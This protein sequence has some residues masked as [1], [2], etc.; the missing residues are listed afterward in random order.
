MH[1]YPSVVFFAV[2]FFLFTTISS[3]FAVPVGPPVDFFAARA[4]SGAHSAYYETASGDFNGDGKVDALISTFGSVVAAFGNGNGTFSEPVT[5]YAP[6]GSSYISAVSGDFNGD[7]RSDAAIVRGHQTISNDIA[8]YLGN[9][10]RTFSAPVFA[11]ATSNPLYLKTL[12]YDRDGKIDLVASVSGVP[13][14]ALMFYRSQG[15]GSFSV[16]PTLSGAQQALPIIHDFNNDTF[17]DIWFYDNSI[18]VIALNTRN[19][20]F[21]PYIATDVSPDVDVQGFGDFNGDGKV[22][23]VTMDGGSFNPWVTIRLASGTY[24]YVTGQDH[25][26]QSR[27]SIY[28]SAVTDVDQDNRPDLIFNSKN[29]T[30]I[31]KGIGDGTFSSTLELLD[32]GSGLF[33]ED[34][35]SDGW[36]D[37]VTAQSFEFVTLGSIVVLLNQQNGNFKSAPGFGM[38]PGTKDI[39][40]ANLN[41]DNFMDFVAVTSG[42]GGGAGSLTV[43][44]QSPAPGR[45]IVPAEPEQLLVGG[46]VVGFN[47]VATGDFNADGRTDIAAAGHGAYGAAPNIQIFTNTGANTFNPLS[48]QIGISDIY[49]VAASDLNSDGRLDLITTGYEGI[50]TSFGIGNGTFAAP[51]R[52]LQ[53]IASNRIAVGDFNNDGRPDFAV[54]TYNINKIAIL[55]NNGTGSFTN[56]LNIPVANGSP[57]GIATAD[58]NT[59]GI[60]D[61]IAS[62]GSGVLV[63]LG[64]GGGNFASPA[65]YPVSQ[66]S[67]YGLA[68]A[69]YNLDSKPDAAVY[70]ATNT[71]SVLLN[72][73]TGGLSRETLWGSGVET[74]ALTAG[75]LNNDSKPDLIAGLTAGTTGYLKLFFNTSAPYVAPPVA[76]A[77]AD[78]DGDGKSD[79]SVYRPSEGNWYLLRSQAGF[80]VTSWGLASD[81]VAPGDFDGD[82]KA[83]FAVFRPSEGNWYIANSNGTFTSGQFGLPGD[84]PV[85]A[86]YDGDGK[87]DRAVFRPSNSTWYILN[88]NGFNVREQAFGLTGDRPVPGDYDGDLKADLSVFR[89]SNGTWYRAN[90]GNGN[91]VEQQWGLNGDIPVNA[92]YDGD[93]KQDY[94]VFRPSAA[95]WYI[96]N[97]S[98]GSYNFRSFGLT[99]DAPVPGDYNGDGSDDI[100]VFRNGFWYIIRSNEVYTVTQFGLSGDTAIPAK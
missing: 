27:D 50:W 60:L 54:A 75:D 99:G 77:R 87:D 28:L 9:G 5:V 10:D 34:V 71:I 38:Q 46:T 85:P 30:L 66:G 44:F 61:L 23:V 21:G 15:D 41:A 65:S 39:A 89:P 58:M 95:S 98:N 82:G 26:F 45:S 84:I 55:I 1:H 8:I 78:F 81:I 29:R 74:K 25:Q 24:T 35:N 31:R 97:S 100:A 6:G 3:G 64:T 51:V 13:G 20:Q 92:D 96:L 79:L 11:N 40:I 90:S 37:I 67:G 57:S 14:T 94:A 18:H 70:S 59:D 36:K 52:Y 93:N 33:V 69:D 91:F 73:G 56:S 16:G 49:D 88:S 19:G 2:I 17:P 22:D 42:S 48:F 83:D 63:M 4:F 32:G 53:N 7:G 76:K 80:N 62:K 43:F 72:N 47:S 68:V 12:D 86:D